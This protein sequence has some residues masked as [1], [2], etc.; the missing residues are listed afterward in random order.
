MSDEPNPYQEGKRAGIHPLIVIFGILLGLWL[1]VFLIVP[2]SKNKQAAGTEGPSRADHRRSRSSAGTLQS[3]GNRLGHE[4]HQSHCS[5]LKRP[6]AK[7]PG[8]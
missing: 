3:P 4:C 1:F 6:T 8:S 2:S 7:L 5:L